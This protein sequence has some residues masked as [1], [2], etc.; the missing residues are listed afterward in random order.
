MNETEGGT[1][2]PAEGA[3]KV[4][5]FYTIYRTWIDLVAV[6]EKSAINIELSGVVVGRGLAWWQ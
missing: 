4:Y 3:T 1:P 6:V 2:V 5:I